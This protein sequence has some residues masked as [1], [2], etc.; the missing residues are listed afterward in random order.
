MHAFI[1]HPPLPQTGRGIFVIC[2]LKESVRLAFSML[3]VYLNYPFAFCQ[4]DFLLIFGIW[5]N[6]GLTLF[7]ML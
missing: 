7:I 4:E 3:G 1:A 6:Y 2:L 5:L